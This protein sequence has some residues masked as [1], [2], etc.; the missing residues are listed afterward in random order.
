MSVPTDYFTWRSAVPTKAE[1]CHSWRNG[2]TERMGK[3]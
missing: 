2:D 1:S 3:S